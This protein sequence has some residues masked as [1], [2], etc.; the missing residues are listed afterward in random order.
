MRRQG[1]FVFLTIPGNPLTGSFLQRL[2]VSG[3]CIHQVFCSFLTFTKSKKC[4]AQIVLCSCPFKGNPLTGSFFQRL[5]VSGN[6][7]H[8]VFCSALTFSESRK[9][10]AKIVLCCCPVKGNPLTGSFL[11][12][13]TASCYCFRQ[14]FCSALTFSEP[15]EG[16]AKIVLCCCPVEGEPVHVCVLLVPHD[17]RLSLPPGVLFPS[18]VFRGSASAVPRLFCVAAHRG[19]PVHVLCSFSASR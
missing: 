8:Q 10:I 3:Y 1:C 16:N 9:C 12:R 11:Q 19:E 17:K 18:H 4:I 15:S 6:R 2:T 7:I 5:L 13:L 14:E